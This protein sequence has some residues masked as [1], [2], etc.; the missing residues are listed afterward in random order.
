MD[1]LAP[2]G[3]SP[4]TGSQFDNRRVFAA[5]IDLAL[6]VPVALIMS[7][8]FGGFSGPAVL[9]TAAWA[10]YYYF[11][12]ESGGGQTLGKRVMK[13]RVA[14]ADGSPLDSGRVAVRTLLRPIDGIGAYLVGLVVMLATGQRRQRLGDLAAGTV[15]TEASASGAAAPKDAVAETEAPASEAEPQPEP[16]PESAPMAEEPVGDTGLRPEPQPE[17]E[18]PPMP[19]DAIDDT[20]LRAEQLPPSPL[21][22][23]SG[24][25][26]DPYE[27]TEPLADPPVEAEPEPVDEGEPEVVIEPLPGAEPEPAPEAI[28]PVDRADEAE[29][30]EPTDEP[31]PVREQ[32]T[33]ESEE[34]EPNEPPRLEIVSS[35]IDMIMAD[36]DEQDEE[37]EPP[38][39]ASA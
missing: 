9:L 34:V 27:V 36:Q 28:V 10:L 8:L 18:S 21:D 17:P 30:T 32:E 24:P 14:R 31:V 13:I 26:Q 11:A 16:E 6:L 35:P 20:G 19:E 1:G 12:L 33:E 5:V 7:A 37:P 4:V 2:A 29:P 38:Q 15:V 25:D 3:P 22:P 39:P 23:S